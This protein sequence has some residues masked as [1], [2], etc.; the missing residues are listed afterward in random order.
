[1]TCSSGISDSSTASSIAM[2]PDLSL[3]LAGASL[4]LSMPK[5]CSALSK[6]SATDA[7]EKADEEDDDLEGMTL[8][9]G[10]LG[11]DAPLETDGVFELISDILHSVEARSALMRDVSPDACSSVALM[12]ADGA[13]ETEAPLETDGAPA[14]YIL[15]RTL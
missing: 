3:S 10:A 4:S 14:A 1:M 6:E 2:S 8:S 15:A 9:T 7:V 5:P 11:T 12:R 13:L